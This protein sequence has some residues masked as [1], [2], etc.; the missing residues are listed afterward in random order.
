[1]NKR[2]NVWHDMGFYHEVKKTPDGKEMPGTKRIKTSL[3]LDEAKKWARDFVN[4]KPDLKSA[5]IRI[6]YNDVKA[7]KAK[8]NSSEKFETNFPLIKM[9]KSKVAYACPKFGNKK[10]P[11]K[12]K[13][14]MDSC[15]DGIEDKK[16][17]DAF[18][19]VFEAVV[20]YFYGEGGRQ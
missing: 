8:T 15:I 4:S 6:F 16:D 7:L 20:G 9:L 10:V 17:F 1:M 11:L 19:L 2:D 12:F 18:I 14:F 3:L 5:Q 13:E